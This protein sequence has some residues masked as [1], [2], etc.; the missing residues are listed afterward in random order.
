MSKKV[1]NSAQFLS[2]ADKFFIEEKHKAG[3][4]LDE[5]VKGVGKNQDL[6]SAYVNTLKKPESQFEKTVGKKKQ[7]T[8]MTQAASEVSDAVSKTI[9][10]AK[11]GF[12]MKYGG[13]M[14]KI[15]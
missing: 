1:M 11:E 6:V 14:A 7:S 3:V 4:S 10:G 15:K 9:G 12:Q 2:N 5:I 13:S 8:V